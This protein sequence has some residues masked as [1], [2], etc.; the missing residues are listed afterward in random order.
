MNINDQAIIAENRK[1]VE[2]AYQQ[3]I[4]TNKKLYLKG[5]DKGTEEYIFPN[6]HEDANNIVNIFYSKPNI[7]VVSITKRTK[8][9]MDGLM[10]QIAKLF[11][12]HIEDNFVIL[13]ENIRFITGMS[14]RSWQDDFE[15]KVPNCFK[16][17]IYHHDQLHNAK[18]NNLKNSLIIIDEIDTGDK[19]DQQLHK[20]LYEA[21]ILNIDSLVKNNN[22][23]ILVS[24]TMIKE[25]YDLYH[26]DKYHENYKMTIPPNY[27]GHKEFLEL[28]IIKEFYPINTSENAEKW[29]KEDIIDNYKNDFRCHIIRD[30]SG[31]NSNLIKNACLKY[32]ILYVEY[33]HEQKKEIPD[34]FREIFKN[35]LTTHVVLVI[36]GLFRRANLIAYKWK[37]KIG[38]VHELYTSIVDN[39]VQVQGLV[40]RMTGYWLDDIINKKHKTGPYRTSIKAIEEYEKIINDPFGDTSYQ[41]SGLRKNNKGITSDNTM[42]SAGIVVGIEKK[43]LDLSDPRRKVPI[44]I[45]TTKENIDSILNLSNQGHKVTK[46]KEIITDKETL[47]I[48]NTYKPVKIS[49]VDPDLKPT[50]K[51]KKSNY[52]KHIT[53]TVNAYNEKRKIATDIMKKDMDKNCYAVFLDQKEN[54]ICM[55]VWNG[56]LKT[57]PKEKLDVKSILDFNSDTNTNIVKQF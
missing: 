27:I 50:G 16:E 28:G 38:A 52:D 34:I 36:K 31:K 47:E 45:S 51:N 25:L 35:E 4:A 11:S 56:A 18:L 32:N 1:E 22:K 53:D 26:W 24:A 12:T 9:G 8:V 7:R 29:I 14:N 2:H 39:N 55:I 57:E 43:E 54:R 20:K 19:V 33:T 44:V 46:L 6:Q 5:D 48:L 42:L 13:S 40:G 10:I 23:L 41:S 49:G 21:D 17:N 37:L 15:K 3:A 30:K